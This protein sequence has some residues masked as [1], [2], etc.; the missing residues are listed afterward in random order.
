MKSC[1]LELQ[2]CSQLFEA[3]VI[4]QYTAHKPADFFSELTSLRASDCDTAVSITEP[5]L[6]QQQLPPGLVCLLASLLWWVCVCGGVQP[7]QDRT[8]LL[9]SMHPS[10]GLGMEE[11]WK[12]SGVFF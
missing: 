2:L 8:Q 6:Q 5:Q 3:V 4:L 12:V 9:A 1:S 11:L 7:Q 10:P